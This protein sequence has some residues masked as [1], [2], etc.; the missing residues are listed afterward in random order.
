MGCC[1]PKSRPVDNSTNKNYYDPE[2][3]KSK[4]KDYILTDN[5]VDSFTKNYNLNDNVFQS[6]KK[7]E[8]DILEKYYKSRKKE[9]ENNMNIYLEKQNLNF[10][11]LLT[12]QIIANEGGRE[13]LE[14]SIKAEIQKINNNKD[15]EKIEY[16]TVMIIGQTGT[17]KS[18]LVNS[19]LKLKG[20]ERAET[21]LTDIVTQRTQAYKSNKVP[22]IQLVDTRGIELNQAFDVDKVGMEA[23]S[24]INQQIKANNVNDFV[25]CIWYCISSNRFQGVE[26]DLV[27]NLINTVASSKIPLIIVMTQ[28]D[29]QEKIEGMKKKIRKKNFENVIAVL[30]EKIKVP[31]GM[32]I[33]AYGLD[34]LTKL[35]VKKCKGAFDGDMKQ[36]MIKNLKER[37]KKT[38][39]SDNAKIKEDIILKMMLDTYKKDLAN[40]NFDD[41]IHDIYYYHVC[42]FLNKNYMSKE[43]VTQIKNSEFNRH[44]NNFFSF[45][46]QYVNKLIQNEL[47]YFSNKFLDIQATKEKEKGRPVDMVNKRNFNDFINSTGNFLITNFNSFSSKFYINFVMTRIIAKLSTNFEQELNLI[48]ENLIL[49]NDIQNIIDECFYKKFSDYEER[50]YNNIS[51]KQNN[52]NILPILEDMNLKNSSENNTVN[53]NGSK[54][55]SFNDNGEKDI[56]FKY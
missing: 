34:K 17:G 48:V 53:S 38:L 14:G 9:F 16:L 50:V 12:R 10:I 23:R 20:S 21:G 35:T 18:T 32:I 41:Y 15:S 44:K 54:R 37:I 26:I 27:N 29:N 24:F 51:K 22:Y 3:I 42:Y 47:P 7:E 4:F 6:I 56:K 25:H 52:N 8:R 2:T 1:E 43:S 45:C 33:P 36:V 31:S 5:I 19:L 28:A 49:K 13:K 55:N 30:A 11:T 39:F 46:Q 40:K